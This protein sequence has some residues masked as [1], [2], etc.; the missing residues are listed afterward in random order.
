MD[1]VR[2]ICPRCQVPTDVEAVFCRCGHRFRTA[3]PINQTTFL[4][5]P[6]VRA[7]RSAVPWRRWAVGAA[8]LV[9]ILLLTNPSRQE[10]LGWLKGQY[11]ATQRGKP[12]PDPAMTALGVGIGMALVGNMVEERNFLLG[13]VFWVE[14]EGNRRYRVLGI[15]KQFIPLDP[16]STAP[17]PAPAPLIVDPLPPAAPP[18]S[19]MQPLPWR[20]IPPPVPDV[21]DGYPRIHPRARPGPPHPASPGWKSL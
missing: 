20:T 8:V 14:V 4:P 7:G 6:G 19:P 13:T 1:Q 2:K 11:L 5:G 9:A 10:Y 15:A 18:V 17:A 16:L 21:L 12:G 3:A